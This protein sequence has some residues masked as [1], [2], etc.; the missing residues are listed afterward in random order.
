MM[1]K[2]GSENMTDLIE[3]GKRINF[4]RTEKNLLLEDVATQVG[5]ATS[6]I[7]RYEKGSISRIK[8]PVIE[9]IALVLN[10][11]A[12]WLLQKSEER[13]P[14][15]VISDT[16]PQI[17]RIISYAKQLNAVGL[18]KLGDYAEDLAENPKYTKHN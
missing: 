6:T 18:A 2:K 8:L 17:D 5:V 11:N 16:D 10:V 4:V 15:V 14:A 7:Q 1:W 13:M 9:K 3:L 12:D